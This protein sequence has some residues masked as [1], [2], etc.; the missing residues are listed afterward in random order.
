MTKLHQI[1]AVVSGQKQRTT[2]ALTEIHHTCQKDLFSGMR[3]T[4]TPLAE[5][6]EKLPP[7]EKLV[8]KTAAGVLAEVR[9]TLTALW[10]LVSVQDDANCIAKADVVLADGTILAIQVPVTHL[11]FLDKQ[12]TDLHTFIVKLPVL[13][14][15]ERWTLDDQTDSYRSPPTD[16]VRTKKVPRSHVAYEATDKHPAQ[17]NTYMEDIQIGAYR[18]EKFHGGITAKERNDMATRC[19]RVIDA[20]KQAREQAN[21]TIVTNSFHAGDAL[22]FVFKTAQS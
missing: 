16:Q 1:V 5:D 8:Q 13:P 7:E 20:I 17:V 4:Y 11:L 10:R 19:Q 9:E 12:F 3:R 22:A 18:T 6:G 15:D 14:P 2:A 21:E